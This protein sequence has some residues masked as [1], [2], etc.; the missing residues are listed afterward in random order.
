MSNLLV[1]WRKLIAYELDVQ[2]R[3]KK[4]LSITNKI[5]CF[6]IV[7]AMI[8]GILETEKIVTA[9]RETLFKA[10]ELGFAMVFSV[11][12][13]LRLWASAENPKYK[14]RL[15]YVFSP[16]AL[17]ELAIV[18]ASWLIAIGSAGY[19]VRGARLI[20][21]TL[22]AKL[23]RYSSALHNIRLAIRARKEELLISLCAAILLM[24][25]SSMALYIVESDV[26]PEQ[27]GSIPRAM[28]WSVV[29]LTTVGYGDV[30]PLT[31]IGRFLAAVTAMSGIGLIA[32]PTSILASA[33]GEVIK[34]K[35][36]TEF[37]AS[38]AR[39]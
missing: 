29:T 38:H 25:T 31:T 3:N 33:F 24:L 26:Q 14:T 32:L 18:L 37:S 12:Y 22:I 17:L 20:R 28:W 11:E 35:K 5:L 4:G 19:L 16:L 9:G 7:A 10:A 23:G 39:A 27:F 8:T 13:L 30:Y 36:T 34:K 1:H 2:L 21:I 6:L 15:H